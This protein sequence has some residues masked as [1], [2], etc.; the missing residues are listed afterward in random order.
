MLQLPTVNEDTGLNNILTDEK[1]T[2]GTAELSLIKQAMDRTNGNI[3]KAARELGVSR[4]AL[5]YRLKKYNL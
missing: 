3:S 1:T 4:M 2:L 5:R